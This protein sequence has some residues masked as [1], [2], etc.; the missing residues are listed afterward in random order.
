[1]GVED[2]KYG[3]QIFEMT[4]RLKKE[5]DQEEKEGIA[6]RNTR[7]NYKNTPLRITNTDKLR[8]M[9]TNH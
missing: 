3:Y 9:T 2:K 8:K 7:L 1:M 6:Q 5:E 4:K